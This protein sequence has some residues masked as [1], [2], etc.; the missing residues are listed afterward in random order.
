M[1]TLR[2]EHSIR[3]FDAWRESFDRDPLGRERS[4]VRRYRVQRPIDD[5]NYVAID[6]DFDGATDAQNFLDELNKMWPRAEA[7]GLIGSP[8]V[9]IVETVESTEY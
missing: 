8:Q 7:S 3:D 2:I 9:R 5:A 4:G 1:H 6:L